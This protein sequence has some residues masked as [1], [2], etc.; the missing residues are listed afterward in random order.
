MAASASNPMPVREVKRLENSRLRCPDM[1]V[2]LLKHSA[3]G[4]DTA[5]LSKLASAS[6]Y[7]TRDYRP[8]PRLLQFLDDLHDASVVAGKIRPPQLVTPRLV[9]FELLVDRAEYALLQP[10]PVEVLLAGGAGERQVVHLRVRQPLLPRRPI[11]R[12]RVLERFLG[13][14]L[15]QRV[16]AV[17]LQVARVVQLGH[18]GALVAFLVLEQ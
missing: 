2:L 16:H 15:V 17:P 18:V 9:G 10:I 12:L 5:A 8:C 1:I 4:A 14:L 6:L 3:T 11:E 13:Q 7:G